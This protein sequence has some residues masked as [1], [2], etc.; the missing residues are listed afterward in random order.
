MLTI[1]GERQGFCDGISRRN[2]LRI[3]GLAVGGL[4]LPDLLR[5]ES[6]AGLQATGKSIINIYLPG[7]PTHMDTFDLKPQAPIEFRGSFRPIDTNVPG[8]QICEHMPKLAQLGDKL[9][10]VRSVSDF[11]NEHSPRQSDSGWSE[12]SLRM[13]GG[14][15]GLGPVVTK[16]HGPSAGC[17]LAS[18]ALSQFTSPGYL[19]ASFKDY[20]PDGE[21]RANLR[22]RLDE[23]R[24]Y[25]RKELLA[26]LDRF[27]RDADQ[28]G[29]MAAADVFTQKAMDVVL[30]G[31][32]ADALDVEKENEKTR[33]TYGLGRSGRQDTR[34]FLVARRLVEAGVRV[35]SFTFGGWDTHGQNFDTLKRQLPT[36][37]LGLSAL[38]RDLDERGLLDSTMILISGE[39]GRTPRVNNGAGRDHWPAA[40][41]AVLAGGGLKTGQVIGSTNHLGERPQDRPVSFQQVFAAIY[42]QLGID[43]DS[44]QLTDSAGRPQYLVENREPIAELV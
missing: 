4:T 24:L 25:Q 42:R 2:F 41:F 18:V 15:P 43:V 14:R 13:M 34:N 3:G 35:V 37:D 10:L 19:G 9:V 17:P 44:A 16:L 12:T 36:M 7:G 38:I 1:Y 23:S 29:T 33:E 22:L 30:S 40:G 39:F 26:G 8:M 21:A 32:I 28:S 5:A 31:T 20:Q 27:R 11:K 6:A